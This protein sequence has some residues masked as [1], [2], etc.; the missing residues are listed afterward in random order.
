MNQAG[1][2]LILSQHE[3]ASLY[4]W[5]FQNRD[6]HYICCW[7]KGDTSEMLKKKITTKYLSIK[8]AQKLWWY[9]LIVSLMKMTI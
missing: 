8:V 2:S 4:T 1:I 7:D 3:L 6:S 9:G 5:L